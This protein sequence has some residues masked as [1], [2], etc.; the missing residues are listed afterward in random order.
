MKSANL[1]GGH[2]KTKTNRSSVSL[3]FTPVCLSILHTSVVFF[4]NRTCLPPSIL[5]YHSGGKKFKG[6][7]DCHV[8]ILGL[9]RMF[10]T[11]TFLVTLYIRHRTLHLHFHFGA[12]F[13]SVLPL[14]SIS[15]YV[16][17]PTYSV[18]LRVSHIYS[19]HRTTTFILIFL[20]SYI[21]VITSFFYSWPTI[22]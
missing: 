10:S 3:S 5:S 6:N 18:W 13:S 15:K 9:K 8:N 22:R 11:R 19:I 21:F 16:V 7:R 12:S 2:Q 14:S 1:A 20:F 17:A 4:C